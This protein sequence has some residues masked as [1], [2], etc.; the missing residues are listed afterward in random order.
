MVRRLCILCFLVAL[1]P[2]LALAQSSTLLEAYFQ[3]EALNAQSRYAEAETFARKALEL[4][5]KEFGPDH[6][7]TWLLTTR[8]RMRS[9]LK[10]PVATVWVSGKPFGAIKVFELD[11]SQIHQDTT[12]VTFCGK[13][14]GWNVRLIACSP[15]WTD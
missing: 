10:S 4:S 14:E 5:R 12:T 1:W 11:C 15:F 7:Y 2:G 13:Y 6:P 3:Y 9:P 8:S